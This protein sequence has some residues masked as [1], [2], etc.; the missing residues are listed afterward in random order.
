MRYLLLLLALPL[1]ILLLCTSHS[2]WAPFQSDQVKE[3][4]SH[5]TA[6]ERS[7]AVGRGAVVGLILGVLFGVIGLFGMPIGKWLFDSYLTGVIIVQP[8]ALIILGIS[9]WKLKPKMD[10]SQKELLASTQWSKEQGLTSEKI[11][12][13][14]F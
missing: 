11:V 3:I 8:V 10:Q 4:C 2:T 7:R 12:L 13:H 9:F 14:R 5:M 1:L 6:K